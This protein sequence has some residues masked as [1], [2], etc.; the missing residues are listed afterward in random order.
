MKIALSQNLDNFNFKETK[1]KVK[2]YFSDLDKLEWEQARLKVEKGLIT[3]YAVSLEDIRKRPFI[4]VGKDEF[5][6]LAKAEKDEELKKDLSGFYW[7]QSILTEQEQ[8]YIIEYFVNGK[9]QD[10]VVGLL[11]L[12][13]SDS[14]A[15]K[16]LK[17]RAIYKFAYVLNLI[18]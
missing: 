9:Y 16:K 17:R 14:K 18:V 15:F 12:N 13:S 4:L 8:L 6:I 5:N 1:E 3:K 11:G 7:A 10:E 2:N